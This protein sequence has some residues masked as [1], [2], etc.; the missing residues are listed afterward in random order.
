LSD[1]VAISGMGAVSSLGWGCAALGEALRAGRDGLVTVRRFP[2]TETRASLGGIVPGENTPAADHGVIARTR[3]PRYALTAIREA[4]EQAG[5]SEAT[6]RGSRTAL[7]V[8]LSLVDDG[9]CLH[10]LL[11]DIKEGLGFDGP[12]LTLSTACCSSTACI[13]LGMAL[14]QSGRFDRVIAGGADA[15]IPALFGG[16]DALGVL[17]E[18]PC[19]PFSQTYGTVVGEGAGFVVLERAPAKPLA[20]LSGFG[21]SNDAWHES[22]PDPSGAGLANAARGALAHAGLAPEQIDYVNAHG[23]GTEANDA[24]ETRA[25]REVF[26]ETLPPVSSTKAALGHAQAAAGSLELIASLICMADGTIPPTLRSEPKRQYVPADCV[27]GPTPR[28]WPVAHLLSNSAAF[29]GANACVIASAAPLEQRSLQRPV[30]LV[31]GAAIGTHGAS[32][33]ALRDALAAGVR[34]PLSPDLDGIRVPR[35][36]TSAMDPSARLLTAATHAALKDARL[37]V[38]RNNRDRV[39]LIAGLVRPSPTMSRAY[40][41]GVAVNG[42]A[43]PP[44]GVFTQLVLNAPA[45]A[46]ARALGLRGPH[47]AVT[48]GPGTGLAAVAVAFSLLAGGPGADALVAAGVD[49]PRTPEAG[50]AYGAA[51]VTLA[52]APAPGD[53]RPAVRLAGLGLADDPERAAAAAMD[54][55]GLV[56]VDRRLGPGVDAVSVALGSGPALDGLHRLVWALSTLRSGEARSALILDVGSCVATAVVLVASHTD[57]V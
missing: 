23:T 11:Q 13:G 52:T 35:V 32:I 39:G 53:P 45:G 26:G 6:L 42:V 54:E 34:T 22:S 4:L 16:F 36:D 7:V 50:H 21:L 27:P 46:C 57:T 30:W 29:G 48:A 3:S 33:E 8:G 2:V 15:L 1:A 55:A 18:E 51:A 19:G 12:A 14:V 31:G 41:A 56:D 28:A 9:D 38:R 43:K 10:E 44:L 5:L 17:S 24:A 37:R 47:T 40:N 49:E 25:L 20:W